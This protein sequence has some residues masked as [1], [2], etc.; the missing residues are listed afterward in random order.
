M[1]RLKRK[2]ILKRTLRHMTPVHIINARR[3]TAVIRRFAS[4]VGLVYFG[5]VSQRDD[6]HR[7][8]RGHTVSATHVDTN[9]CVGSLKGYDVTLVSRNDIVIDHKLKLE[10]R[11]HWL[12]VTIDFKSSYDIP[13]CYIG[14]SSRTSVFASSFEQLVPLPLNTLAAYPAAFLNNYTMYAKP[15]HAIELESI[16]IPQITEVI[17]SHFKHASIEIEDGSIYLYIES[18]HPTEVLVEKMV[19]N[20]IWLAEAID[21]RIAQLQM[22]N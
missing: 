15:T 18:E 13:H 3:T 19:S 9:Y 5:P 11:C 16:I 17:V 4:K 2:A 12:I 1:K 7:L 6:D 20:G 22:S 14:H 8:V 10:Q 21:A